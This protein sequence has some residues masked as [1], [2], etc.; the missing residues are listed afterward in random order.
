MSLSDQVFL[1][2]CHLFLM[3]MM[4]MMMMMIDVLRQLVYTVG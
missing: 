2:P 3:I 4:M 1:A